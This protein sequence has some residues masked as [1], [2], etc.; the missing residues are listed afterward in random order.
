MPLI[1]DSISR[2][3]LTGEAINI[4]MAYRMKGYFERGSLQGIE[5]M[6]Q[7]MVVEAKS[8]SYWNMVW[9]K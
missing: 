7:G 2:L 8:D 3:N 1:E 5:N 9:W 6:D 4:L